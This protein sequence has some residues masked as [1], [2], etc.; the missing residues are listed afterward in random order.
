MQNHSIQ[1]KFFISSEN[2]RQKTFAG[3]CSF[4][5]NGKGNIIV[6]N[7]DQNVVLQ[8]SAFIEESDLNE[9]VSID[10]P[11]LSEMDASGDDAPQLNGS[12]KPVSSSAC[13]EL[14]EASIADDEDIDD[15]VIIIDSP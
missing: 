7:R 15:S 6:F 9:S 1:P 4:K 3:E 13:S 14:S 11:A 2:N 8:N 10:G 5:S 12:V